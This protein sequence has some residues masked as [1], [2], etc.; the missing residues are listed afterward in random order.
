VH[1]PYYDN[2]FKEVFD[3]LNEAGDIII[4]NLKLKS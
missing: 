1:D 2:K 4:D 3:T